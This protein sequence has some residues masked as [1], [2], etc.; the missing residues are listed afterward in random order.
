[1]INYYIPNKSEIYIVCNTNDV[2]IIRLTPL[3]Y[4]SLC[5]ARQLIILMLEIDSVYGLVQILMYW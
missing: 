4:V 1:M 2:P 3:C 5:W